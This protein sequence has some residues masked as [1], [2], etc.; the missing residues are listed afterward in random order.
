MEG[1]TG[2]GDK[3][4]LNI[5]LVVYSGYLVFDIFYTLTMD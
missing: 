1:M 2:I 5:Y 4:L 3:N